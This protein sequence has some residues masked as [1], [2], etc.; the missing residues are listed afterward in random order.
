[1]RLDLVSGPQDPWGRYKSAFAS[2]RRPVI[3]RSPAL[4]DD[5][6]SRSAPTPGGCLSLAGAQILTWIGAEVF[7]AGRIAEKVLLPFV[8][9]TA[10][11]IL[12]AYLHS[13][14]GVDDGSACR[15]LMIW[16]LA[17]HP[18]YQFGC[19]SRPCVE[20]RQSTVAPTFRACP[21]RGEG[22]AS[23]HFDPVS[24]LGSL[25]S[26]R[27]RTAGPPFR[28]PPKVSQRVGK[29]R[30][31][32]FLFN[33]IPALCLHLLCFHIYSRFTTEPPT[34]VLCFQ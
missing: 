13:A 19:S 3:L 18:G 26:R 12:A 27:S 34:P 6:A 28:L 33:N 15:G 9:V 16:P 23:A 21:E 30:L 10:H 32:P 31:T 24:N 8:H 17:T 29:S 22:P 1:M 20:T 14:N 11:R 2:S 4:W 25:L 7:K 5:E